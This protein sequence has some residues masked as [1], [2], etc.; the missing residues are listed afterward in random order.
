MSPLLGLIICLLVSG[1]AALSASSPL[2]ALVFPQIIPILLLLYFLLT[3]ADAAAV[4]Q[5]AHPRS[6]SSETAG[7]GP[8]TERE[9]MARFC[10][11]LQ[12]LDSTT[13]LV[14]WG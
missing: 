4:C 10:G 13:L 11:A 8:L 7:A 14:C 6:F 12:C 1:Y 9:T 2:K 3:A 5:G